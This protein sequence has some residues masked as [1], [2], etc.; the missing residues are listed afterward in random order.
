MK[1]RY[2]ALV[3]ICGI[4]LAAET[5]RPMFSLSARLYQGE[6]TQGDSEKMAFGGTKNDVS[7]TT[8]LNIELRNMGQGRDSFTIDYYFLCKS[9]GVENYQI[10]DYGS[11]SY[12]LDKMEAEKIEFESRPI[13]KQI[14][15]WTDGDKWEFGKNAGGFV[16]ILKDRDG[17][18]LTARSKI[19]KLQNIIKDPVKLESFL[20]QTNNIPPPETKGNMMPMAPTAPMSPMMPQQEGHIRIKIENK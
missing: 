12:T 8:M 18:I 20:Q 10:F 14:Y 6:K 1:K 4:C 16:V 7:K 11:E 19:A 5:N 17:K 9:A 13:K 15:L 3:F 2:I